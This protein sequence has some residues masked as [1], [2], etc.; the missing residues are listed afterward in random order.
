MKAVIQIFAV[1]GLATLLLS[2]WY[3]YCR[4][5]GRSFG[6]RIYN[7]NVTLGVFV[8]F[9]VLTLMTL[10]RAAYIGNYDHIKLCILTLLLISMP[11]ILERTLKIKLPT[12]MEVIILCFVFAAEILGEINH[13]Y[14]LVSG[15]DT[16][17]HTLNGFLCAALGFALVDILNRSSRTSLP[18]SPLYLAITAF[19][20]SMTIGVLWEFLEFGIDQVFLADTQ[21]DFI[22]TSFASTRLGGGDPIVIKDIVETIITTES[23]QVLEINGYLDIDII[24]TMKDLFVNFI[25]ALCFSII[26][27]FYVKH[28]GTGKIASQFIPQISMEGGKQNA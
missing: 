19:C 6:P 2:G 17:L 12:L 21:K 22:V 27:F 24:D 7:S 18:L 4:K 26:G 23:G 20:F 9:R 3:I 5:T 8:F 16:A 1:I 13:F 28:R 10:V 11:S 25:G 15:W 14:T